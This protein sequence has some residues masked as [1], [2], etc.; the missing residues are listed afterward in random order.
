[1]Q[2]ASNSAASRAKSGG[3]EGTVVADTELSEVNGTE[4]RLVLRG[5]AIERFAPEASLEDAAALLWHG[6]SADG[7]A[8]LQRAF[9]AG[10]LRA[11]ALL[12]ELESALSLADA[13]ASLRAAIAQL[14]ADLDA[15]SEPS[16][17]LVS[18]EGSRLEF[19]TRSAP[20]ILM[21]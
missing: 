13:M 21:Q 20:R 17:A 2:T 3:L 16:D 5:H 8:E 15:G 14:P 9:A 12:P 19:S 7:D 4:G 6:R 10:R 11:F 1:M 18:R